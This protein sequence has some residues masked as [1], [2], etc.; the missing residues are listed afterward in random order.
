MRKRWYGILVGCSLLGLLP[1]AGAWS[2]QFVGLDADGDSQCLSA[3]DGGQVWGPGDVGTI[4]TFNAFMSGL[5]PLLSYGCSFC[6]T[7][8]SLVT[9]VGFTYTSPTGWTDATL[10]NSVDSPGSVP[11]SPALTALY[12]NIKCWLAQSTDF[13]FGNPMTLPAAI[14]TAQFQIAAEGPIYWLLDGTL[15]GWLDLNF[16]SG[17]FSGV[18]QTCNTIQLAPTESKSW[19]SVK[20]LFR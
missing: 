13:T 20:K 4:H 17:D 5:D 18:G 15:C 6:V 7:E 1:A 8:P 3:I 11:I 2:A 14:G 9:G 19:G 16:I 10:Q 12:P